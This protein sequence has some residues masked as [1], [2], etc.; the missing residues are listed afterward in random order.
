MHAYAPNQD[1]VL[2]G[3]GHAHVEV[4]R[5]FGAMPLPG[6]RL[7]L[8]TK[9]AHTAYRWRCPCSSPLCPWLLLLSCLRLPVTCMQ[10]W[11]TLRTALLPQVMRSTLTTAHQQTLHRWQGPAVCFQVMQAVACMRACWPFAQTGV[12]TYHGCCAQRHAAGLRV[13]LLQLR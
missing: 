2:V 8:I 4:L 11:S 10:G 1:L 5:S 13:R 7:T 6:V 9:D 3:G 12:H